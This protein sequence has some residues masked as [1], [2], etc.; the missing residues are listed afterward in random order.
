[1]CELRHIGGIKGNFGVRTFEYLSTVSLHI[2]QPISQVIHSNA[3]EII[4]Q[5]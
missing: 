4:E 1:M 5:Q 2:S 3:K